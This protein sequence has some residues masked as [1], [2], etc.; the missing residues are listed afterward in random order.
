MK[1]LLKYFAIVLGIVIVI[2]LVAPFL[3]KDQIVS[4][5]KQEA[6][7]QL[8]AA[9]D[10]DKDISLGFFRHFPNA[11]LGVNDLSIVGKNEYAGDTLAY[12]GE[13][14]IVIDLFSLFGGGTYQI[15]NVVLD[16]PYI[17]LLVDSAGKANWDIVKETEADTA[18][19]SAS[20]F[21]VALQQYAIHNGRLVFSDSSTGFYLEARGLDHSGKGDFTQDVFDLK[22]QSHAKALTIAY[23]GVPY[24]SKIATDIDADININVPKSKY[25]FSQSTLRLN[26]LT[27]GADGW[28]AL[29]DSDDIAMD[30]SFSA[31]EAD[32]KNF[33]SLI[34]AIYQK[35][36]DELKASG[37]MMFSG[38]V[39]GVYNTQRIP[40]FGLQLAVSDGMFQYPSV[41]EPLS[42]VNL[43][44]NI[45]NDDGNIDHTFINVKQ[46][47][48]LLGNNP[49][50]AHLTV[51]NPQ[52]D[53][54]IDG[55]VKGK[56]N[57]SEVAKIYPLEEG[58]KL[59]GMLDIDVQAKGRMS[60]I[61]QENY[62]DFQASGEILANNLLYQSTS[63]EQ[64]INIPEGK[65]AFSPKAVK[66][67]DFKAN[68]GESDLLA[69]GGLDNFFGYLFSQQD[70]KGTLDI[71][72]QLLNL[73]QI[74][75]T[76]STETASAAETTTDTTG[77]VKAVIIPK[78]INFDLTTHIGRFV[79]DNYD[80]RNV[81]GRVKVADGI[82]T[83]K[84][85]SANMLEGNA[86]LSGT[87]NTQN[88]EVPKT[89][90]SFS[91]DHIDIQKAF[92]TFNTVQ[93]LAPVAAFVQ[94]NFSGNVDFSTLLNGKLYPKLTTVNS[95]GQLRFPNLHITGFDPLKQLAAKL[96][97]PKLKDLDLNKL[98]IHFKIDSGFLKVK[99]FDLTVDGIKMQVAGKNGLNKIIDYTIN[100]KIPREKL[101]DANKGLTHLIANANQAAGTEI[102]LGE[103]VDI[104]VHMGGTITQP[105]IK[106]DLSKEKGQVTNALKSAAQQK[107]KDLLTSGSDSTRNKQDTAEKSQPEQ[108]A[109]KDAV[110]KGLNSL[111]NKKKDT[112]GK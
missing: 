64:R 41:P 1:K 44:L 109:L 93:A 101:G 75:G 25:T 78:N 76:D 94:G 30:L 37:K 23:S 15:R 83:I 6:N 71:R 55:A 42:Q 47:H 48:F 14:N 70:L 36:F 92:K 24:L 38:F 39:K 9:V 97:I 56:L 100:M 18:S 59:G 99:P 8:N 49:F 22:T 27:I 111:F 12:I 81:Q 88:P 57:L 50:D 65:L 16:D 2:L 4:K 84:N 43:D 5:I 63:L 33:L 35:N 26:G 95:L 106:L 28:V 105:K 3:F 7:N 91:A 73:N 96:N 29:P 61:E 108:G 53:P 31:Q 112:S 110:K 98:L 86:K 19:T 85:I 104:T 80:L 51:Q 68:I 102:D 87:Y 45:K 34:P 40:A 13:L 62:S 77:G 74:M 52:S 103:E 54:L 32:F 89:D 67:S 60:A 10:F 82:L 11:S 20:P 79:Y 107:L 46:L 17:Q 69:N 72:S 90:I 58:T 66:V 21:K